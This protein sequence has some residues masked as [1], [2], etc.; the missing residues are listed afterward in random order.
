M[1]LNA[2]GSA[3]VISGSPTKYTVDY[4]F[5]APGTWDVTD[6]G[7]YTISI[8]GTVSDGTNNIAKQ[9]YD[10]FYVGFNRTFTVD[11]LSIDVRYWDTDINYN[12]AAGRFADKFC[13]GG[14]FR[15]DAKFVATVKVVLP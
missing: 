3:I 8:V 4:D 11:K 6:N 5:A 1:T 15:C 14:T 10:Q 2:A 12:N 9:D 13:T 7:S